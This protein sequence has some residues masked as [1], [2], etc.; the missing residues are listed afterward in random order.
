MNVLAIGCHPDDME[1]GCVGTLIK[2]VKRG[3]KV[4]MCHVA[5]GDM[6]HFIIEPEELRV[7]RTRECEDSAKLVGAEPINIDVGDGMVDFTNRDT[8]NKLVEVVRYTKPD[9]IITHNPDDYM[10]D[11]M[12]TSR[13]AYDV[14]FLSTIKHYHP[15][16]ERHEKVAALYYFDTLAGINFIPTEYVDITDEIELKLEALNCHQSQLKWMK[17]HDHIDFLDFV[18]T[19]SKFRGLQ[20]GVPYAEGFR[21]YLGW[22]RLVPERLLP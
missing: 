20:C 5:N 9:I 19:C 15:T 22:P 18:R 3:D 2:Y 10:S 11:H 14:N 7:I 21:P 13:L 6:G 16:S 4:F 12:N 8:I 1:I 17:D